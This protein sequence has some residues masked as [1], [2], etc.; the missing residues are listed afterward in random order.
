MTLIL[1]HLVAVVATMAAGGVG[2]WF[3]RDR[4]AHRS[5]QSA[6]PAVVSSPES[7]FVT[8]V[9]ATAAGVVVAEKRLRRESATDPILWA[10]ENYRLV[11]GV[12]KGTDEPKHYYTR[13]K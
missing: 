2:G 6:A 9:F 11:A 13:V 5:N 10:G 4:H 7:P 12:R 1:I 8:C 3:A